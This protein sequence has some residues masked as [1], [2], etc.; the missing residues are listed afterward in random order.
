M[1][2]LTDL[3]TSIAN[4]IRT[5]KGTSGTIIASNFPSEIASIEEKTQWETS[6]IAPAGQTATGSSAVS[7]GLKKL[8]PMVIDN[9]TYLLSFVGLF[10]GLKKLTDIS[11]V[12]LSFSTGNYSLEQA[13]AQCESISGTE[14]HNFFSRNLIKPS[15]LS[16]AFSNTKF[17]S[18]DL[19]N[20]DVSNCTNF[21][22]LFQNNT[23]LNSVDISNWRF[24]SATALNGMFW[25]VGSASISL[26]GSGNY[27]N[28][29]AFTD[30]C[31]ESG[32]TSATFKN[33]YIS[34]PTYA[35]S[36]STSITNITFDKCTFANSGG[37]SSISGI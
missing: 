22:S 8:P 37:T 9:S 17:S 31:R 15:S 27:Q 5:K 1:S 7:W 35:F 3:F 18:I 10:R 30:I 11:E 36:S 26:T 24:E 33:F 23:N 14:I 4:A 29:I 16:N 19:T 21:S 13:F 20:L 25:K 28:S 32:V 2:A 6:P 12:T 34:S